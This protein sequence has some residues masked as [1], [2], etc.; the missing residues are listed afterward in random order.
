MIYKTEDTIVAISTPIGQ[1]GLG[2]I[3][4]SGPSSLNITQKIF[5]SSKKKSLFNASSHTIYHGWVS[6]S[7]NDIDE[8]LVSVFRKPHSYT[9]ED[10]TEISAHGGPVVLNEIQNLCLSKGARLAR[11]GEFTFRAF[12]YGRM[13]LTRAEA[14]ADLISSKTELT[15]KS[16]INQLKGGLFSRIQQWRKALIDLLSHIEVSLDHSEEDIHFLTRDEMLNAAKKMQNQI[17]EIQKSANKGK[18][19]REGLKIAIIGKPNVGKSSLLNAFLERDRAIVTEIPGTT[20]DII[21]ET[22]DLK[23][24]PI[25]IMDTAGLRHKTRDTVEK[26]G[27]NRTIECIK[28][29]DLVLWLLD[30]SAKASKEDAS[31]ANILKELASD[32][33]IIL[34]LNKIDL[35]AKFKY[36]DLTNLSNK[37]EIKVKISVLTRKNFQDLENAVISWF[38]KSNTLSDEPFLINTRHM[39]ALKQTEQSLQK[40]I[41]SVK[42]K[43]TED[44]IA[45][46]LRESLDHL[47]EITGETA[48]EKI[49]EN[50]FSNFCIGK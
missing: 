32:N 29:S 40:T 33:K 3:R 15:A 25:V 12:I 27:Q 30:S 6:D 36:S 50:I 2:I 11:P 47:G 18:Y 8:V 13:D 22:L 45:F 16:S 46:N 48:T 41:N 31:I 20:R 39:Q 19:L 38:K 7:K 42:N 44:L 9:G 21:E 49:L 14:V 5:K 17:K 37:I 28:N 26:I 35:P 23:G 1:S 43:E 24:I 10:M 4:L 34:V